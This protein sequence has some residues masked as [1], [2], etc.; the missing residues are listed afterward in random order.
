M[1]KG[2]FCVML[3][4]SRNAVM[5]VEGV[6]NFIDKLSLMGYNSLML[7]TEDTYEIP[8]EPLFGYMRGRYTQNEIKI[9]DS[10]A[11]S[12]GI[13]LIP[14]IQTLAHLDQ[15][16]PWKRFQKI[17][18]I[19]N[20][21]LVGEEKT[22]EFIESMFASCAE[23]FTSRNIN[24]GMDEAHML[25]LGK[26]LDR[27]GYHTRSEILLSH[28]KRVCA[29]AE[30]Y[31][32]KPMM[33][34]DM[35]FKLGSDL[36][37]YRED[38][39]VSQEAID[40]VPQNV[41]L[42]YWDYTPTDKGHYA[43]VIEKHKKFNRNLWFAG[44]ANM[45]RNYH[46]PNEAN[47]KS[48]TASI[49][50]CKE[51]GLQNVMVTIW[52]DYGNECPTDSVLPTLAYASSV[53][54]G[55]NDYKEL[56]A[57]AVGE[58]FDD[59]ML[60]D[61]K[62]P[63]EFPK[64]KEYSN[65]SKT[66]LYSDCFLGRF[67]SMVFG[68]GSEK[69]EFAKKA[70]EFAKAKSRSKNYA[71]LFDFYQ[72]YCEVIAIKYDLGYFTRLYY[73]QGNKAELKKLLDDYRKLAP[74]LE[75]FIESARTAWYKTY[76]PHGFDAVEIRLG[77]TLQRAKSCAKRLSDYLDGKISEI[78]E[79]EEKLVFDDSDTALQRIMTDVGNYQTI[80]TVNRL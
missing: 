2:Y 74:S 4:C 17:Q 71:Y 46:A 10:Y 37:N 27:N 50:A 42:I 28:L 64:Q 41:E 53:Y 36:G 70:E 60:A 52:G 21:L 11:K 16:F 68:D 14:C 25:G 67:D 6:K 34:S 15:I 45:G 73:Q 55:N 8:G 29:I 22:Y 66:M 58:N 47:M 54:Y 7:Y 65:G 76:K 48:L 13:E 33:W 44:C 5:S 38:G 19:Y 26:Y 40:S 24:V 62:M 80:A 72:K 51:T 9:I 43:R 56:F 12:K 39:E 69:K 63:P 35:F 32:F 3:D 31:G 77:G 59:F 75:E 23:C 61:M 1:K 78:P 30:K 79:L 57:R 18:D 20:I 49:T